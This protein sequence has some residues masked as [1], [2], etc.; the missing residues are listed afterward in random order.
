VWLRLQGV[1]EHGRK[2]LGA[3]HIQM[4]AILEKFSFISKHLWMGACAEVNELGL[5]ITR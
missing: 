1:R 3:M 2:D 4:T 5:R